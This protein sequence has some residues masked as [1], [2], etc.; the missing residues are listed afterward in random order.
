MQTHR[1]IETVLAPFEAAFTKPTLARVIVLV[2]GAIF[3]RGRRTVTRIIA[4]LGGR[5]TGD[6]SDYHRVLSR[7]PWKSHIIF[8]AIASLVLRVVP[9]KWSL[10]V[11][12]DTGTKHSGKNV[13]GNGC[14][15]DAVRS[16]QKHT[17]FF[18]GHKWVVMCVLVRFPWFKRPLALPILSLLYIP[19]K[20]IE[21]MKKEGINV[22]HRSM[23]QLAMIMIWFLAKAFPT[24]KFRFLGDG[25]YSSQEMA[26][27]CA[28]MQD[29][30]ALVGKFHPEAN[31]YEKPARGSKAMKG[32]K[33]I[34]PSEQIKTGNFR[35]ATVRW[36]NSSSRKVKYKSGTGLWYRSGQGVV[37][38]RWV[39]VCD[40]EGNHRDEYFFTTDMSMSEV[41]I[42]ESYTGRWNIETTFQECKEHL[43]LDST[44]NRTETSVLRSAPC[45]LGLYTLVALIFHEFWKDH[46]DDW[47]KKMDC[48]IGY[49]G[50]VKQD[51]TFTDVLSYVRRL[52]FEQLLLNTLPRNRVSRFLESDIGKF[53]LAQLVQTT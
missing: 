49:S 38:V 5:P 4:A 28:K 10:I 26:R 22:K 9:D 50:Y 33:M 41:E 44:R 35:H 25:G 45:L 36:Y 13:F 34:K 17:A 15:R 21:K 39:Y 40:M 8:V 53:V 19:P 16:S 47:R 46:P 43:G 20:A 48:E 24:R 18:F 11:F 12:D 14:H 27:F 52:I 31:L 29:R 42:I 51:V 1:Y 32:A 6:I 23:P 2:V 37:E 3:C 30:A 7:A